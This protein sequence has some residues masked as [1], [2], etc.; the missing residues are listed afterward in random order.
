MTMISHQ[1]I[2]KAFTKEIL[3]L[4]LKLKQNLNDRADRQSRK[5][6]MTF[7]AKGQGALKKQGMPTSCF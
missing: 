3:I 7:Q 1:E 5:A 4:S 6:E 2:R